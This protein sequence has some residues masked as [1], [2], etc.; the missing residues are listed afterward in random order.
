MRRYMMTKRRLYR[1]VADTMTKDKLSVINNKK[2]E[3]SKALTFA[4]EASLFF[5]L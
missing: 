1:K 2:S 5:I 4:F 3:A